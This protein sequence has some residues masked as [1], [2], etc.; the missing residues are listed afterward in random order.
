MLSPKPFGLSR[1]RTPDGS[2]VVLAWLQRHPCHWTVF[3]ANRVSEIQSSRP[4]T[5]WRH[6]PTRDNP[7]DCASRGMHPR[8]LVSV[9]HELWW[10]GRSGSRWHR[11]GGPRVRRTP[12]PVRGRSAPNCDPRHRFAR[13]LPVRPVAKQC[14]F[15]A[16]PPPDHGTRAVLCTTVP[17]GDRGGWGVVT[18]GGAPSAYMVASVASGYDLRGRHCRDPEKRTSPKGQPAPP[19]GPVRGRG[20]FDSRGGKVTARPPPVR[21]AAPD[22]PPGTPRCEPD[23]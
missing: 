7:A 6:V 22:R 8:E 16:A 9:L 1:R 19:A 4:A 5:A 20:R 13:A 21:R 10:K 14:L 18:V 2:R 17:S 3:V 12:D 11:R 23:N 15:M